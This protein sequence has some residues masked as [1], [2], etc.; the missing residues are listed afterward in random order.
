MKKNIFEIKLINDQI[1]IEPKKACSEYDYCEYVDFAS[2]RTKDI[3]GIDYS[4]SA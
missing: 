1:E 4:G 2:C 3:C